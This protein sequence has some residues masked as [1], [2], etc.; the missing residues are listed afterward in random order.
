MDAIKPW[1]AVFDPQYVKKLNGPHVKKGKSLRDLADQVSEDIARFK[2][3]KGLSRLVM[4]V[5]RVHR[6][7]P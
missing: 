6:G 7:L 1:P 3:E 2:K 4:D 5:V